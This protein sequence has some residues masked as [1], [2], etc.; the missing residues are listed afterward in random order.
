MWGVGRLQVHGICNRR[1]VQREVVRLDQN[2]RNITCSELVSGLKKTG[3][4][5]LLDLLVE[6]KEKG[7]CDLLCVEHF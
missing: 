5:Y 2:V 1:L 4:L 7:W 6:R 3:F